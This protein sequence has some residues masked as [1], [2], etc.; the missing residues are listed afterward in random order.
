MSILITIETKNINDALIQTVNARD[1]HEFLE[2][3]QK[4]ADWI[5]DR[6][7]QYGFI[8]S[9][10]FIVILGKTPNG[11]RPTKEYAISLD[12]AKEL[13]MVERNEKGKQA[14]QYFIECERRVLQP[15]TLL[16]T[17]KELALMVVRA[18]E[19]KE[20]LLLENKSLSTE[21]D[22]LKNLFKE[23]MTPTQFS[24]MLNGVNSQQINHFLA[25][26]KWLYNESKSGN[27]LRW[28]VAATARDKYLTE[29]QNEISPHGANSFISYRPVLLRKGAQRLYDQYLAD[30]LPMKKN[31]N[32]LHTHDKTIQ[33]VA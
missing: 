13:S 15:Q 27:N 2:S 11:G 20:Q 19:E 6:I 30:K 29:K 12:M 14:R 33:I 17:A 5:K 21:N 22:C 3:K 23:G 4:F 9:Q 28:R 1:L 31:W 26:L 10:D 24:K 8:E 18:E 25:G 16:P 7:Q 32:G